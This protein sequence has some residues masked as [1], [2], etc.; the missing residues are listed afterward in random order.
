[1]SHDQDT[2]ITLT[3]SDHPV[4]LRVISFRGHEALNQPY[5]FD[6]DLIS[7]NPEL[8]VDTLQS[9]S[10]YLCFGPADS[11]VHGQIY[12]ARQLYVGRGVSHYRLRLAPRLCALEQP[13]HRRIFQG[14]SAPQ[15][16]VQLLNEHGIDDF[17]FDHTL[18]LYPAR[19]VC[20]QYDESDLHFFHRLC[21]EEGIH[22]RFEHS[23][24]GHG[25][26]FADDPASFIEQPVAT[27]FQM[28]D[29]RRAREPFISHMAEH[30]S[31][32]P[33]YS[34]HHESAAERRTAEQ[35]NNIVRAPERNLA[36]NQACDVVDHR[37]QHSPEALRRR[38]SSERRLERLRCERRQV[39]GHSNQPTLISGQI[40]RVFD[41]PDNLFNDQWLL[42]EIH[43]AGKQPQVL[44]GLDAADIAAIFEQVL[45]QPRVAEAEIPAFR[46]GYRNHFRAIPWAMPFRPPLRHRKPQARSDEY[47]TLVGPRDEQGQMLAR[48][49]W[50]SQDETRWLP[51]ITQARDEP[52]MAGVRVRVSY[53]DND[54]DRP[55]ICEVLAVA[56]S[57]RS[58]RIRINGV[59][60]LPVAEHIHMGAGQ[61]LQASD[62]NLLILNSPNSR[63]ELSDQCI[64]I[65]GP[66][67]LASAARQKDQHTQK[68]PWQPD[69]NAL[70]Q[71]LKPSCP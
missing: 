7:L 6:I 14:L 46:R 35:A 66:Q 55:V 16:M 32:Q 71:W 65:S 15:I 57:R 23:R 39:Q 3:I 44:K 9:C 64:R 5:R 25:L 28:S 53:L 36:A 22:Y 13:G 51:M 48:F 50:Q 31:I 8:N 62:R 40:F 49:D 70:F 61:T 34:S 19:A 43:H 20:T 24:I 56:D 26:V 52:I 27:R 69:L 41:H 47:A 33:S 12:S 11:G 54:P 38:Q 18:G 2:L 63:I 59:P 17:R 68:T 37:H 45:S 42:T 21:E 4:P 58:T 60:M 30:F 29:G 10:A 67:T 1:M